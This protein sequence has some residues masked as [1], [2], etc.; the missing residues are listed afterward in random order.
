MKRALAV[1]ALARLSRREKQMLLGC[2][3]CVLLFC[4]YMFGPTDAQPG[5]ELAAAPPPAS[6]APAPPQPP[7]PPTVAARPAVAPPASPPA[8][9]ADGVVLKGV[10]GGGPR[11]GSAILLLPSGVQRRVPIGREVMPGV[12]LKAVEI[13]H[14]VLVGADGEKRIELASGAAQAQGTSSSLQ[15]N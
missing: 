5:V 8:A 10:L 3:A 7:S 11:G 13:G 4:L 2:G 12:T 1:P 14:A 6:A 9:S 15:V